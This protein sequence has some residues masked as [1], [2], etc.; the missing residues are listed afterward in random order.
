MELRDNLSAFDTVRALIC[1]PWGALAQAEKFPSECR[2]K[3]LNG[4]PKSFCEWLPR[5]LTHTSAS[6]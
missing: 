5:Q 1:K 4:T 6:S 3:N 2:K